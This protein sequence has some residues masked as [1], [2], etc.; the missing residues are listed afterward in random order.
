VRADV[1]FSLGQLIDDTRYP[2]TPIALNDLSNIDAMESYFELLYI[3]KLKDNEQAMRDKEQSTANKILGAAAIG[4]TGLGL[5][6]ALSGA[7]EQSADKSAEEDMKAYLATFTCDFG[8]GRNIKGGEA[9]IDL[10]DGNDLMAAVAE[11]RALAADLKARKE[12]LGKTPGIE[13]EVIIDAAETGL[14]DN[15]GMGRQSGAYT[16]LSK[17]L[18][19]ETSADAEAWAKQKGDAKN[20]TKTGAIIAAGATVAAVTANLVINGGDD[21]KEKSAEIKREYEK[22]KISSNNNTN[23]TVIVTPDEPYIQ[24]TPPQQDNPQ[25]PKD[26]EQPDDQR[27]DPRQDNP[28]KPDNQEHPDD[29]HQDNPQKPDNQEHPDDQQPENHDHAPGG[30]GGG[31]NGSGGNG[32]ESDGVPVSEWLAQYEQR[33]AECNKKPNHTYGFGQCE[34]NPPLNSPD[35][36]T[37]NPLFP[38]I[39]GRDKVGGVCHGA[40]IISGTIVKAQSGPN[41]GTCDCSARACRYST[42]MM[43]LNDGSEVPRVELKQMTMNG[44]SMGV[45][46]EKIGITPSGICQPFYQYA[47]PSGPN[48]SNFDAIAY[49]ICEQRCAESMKKNGCKNEDPKRGRVLMETFAIPVPYGNDYVGQEFRC[50]CAATDEYFEENR[51]R[52]QDEAALR[53]ELKKDIKFEQCCKGE[54]SIDRMHMCRTVFKDGI[55]VTQGQGVGLIKAFL[56]T[57]GVASADV[58]CDTKFKTSSNDDHIM[59]AIISVDG[60]PTQYSEFIFDSLNASIDSTINESMNKALCQNIYGFTYSGTNGSYCK[61]GSPQ[62]CYELGIAGKDIGIETKWNGGSC[63][64]HGAYKNWGNDAQLETYAGIDNKKFCRGIQMQF[65]EK[66]INMLKQYITD[67]VTKNLGTAPKKI[68]CVNNFTHIAP[69]CGGGTSD[70]VVRCNVDD[71]PIDFVFDDLSENFDYESDAAYQALACE[72]VAGGTYTGENCIGIDEAR[73][74]SV[75]VEAAKQCPGCGRPHWDK[76]KKACILPAGKSASS[77]HKW[78]K[79]GTVAGVTVVA[80]AVTVGTGGTGTAGTVI[81]LV[82]L[83]GAVV[84]IGETVNISNKAQEFLLESQ[85]CKNAGCAETMIKENMQRMANFSNDFQDAELRAIDSELARLLQLIPESSELWDKVTLDAYQKGMF[86][87]ASWEKE[88][89]WRAVGAAMQLGSLITGFIKKGAGKLLGA[90]KGN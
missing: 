89:I 68:Q 83:T 81:V 34:E 71:H 13:S 72:I 35:C 36:P 69:I 51:K 21:K 50:T 41:A 43:E 62:A 22:N 40:G 87:A 74:N 85:K 11:Y 4:A 78:E 33:E 47:I 24:K 48:T 32:N 12:A 64:M 15:V 30:N 1:N 63:Q 18:T 67:E 54:Q 52:L 31:N 42:E 66:L 59:C 38:S 90:Q 8:Q 37:R 79:I 10:P 20:K 82:E 76:Q 45:C 80:A 65:N 9:N 73:C 46:V 57:K 23:Q 58:V 53:E 86:D 5:M 88:Q 25:Q 19:D 17:A 49:G 56:A 3:Q 6:N 77:H 61:T 26:Q 84:E 55:K 28:Q 16:S 14:Y 27:D 60:A 70:D 75:A 39:T 7:A 29:P 2:R 44:V